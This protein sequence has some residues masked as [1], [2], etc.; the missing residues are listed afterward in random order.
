MKAH[1]YYLSPYFFLEFFGAT[2]VLWDYKNHNQYSIEEKY[3]RRL[4]EIANQEGDPSSPLDQ[5]LLDLN[6]INPYIF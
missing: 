6:L 5:E 2:L 4:K 3:L 1:P